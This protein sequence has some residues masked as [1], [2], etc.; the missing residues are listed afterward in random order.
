MVEEG[1][2]AKLKVTVAVTCKADKDTDKDARTEVKPTA[3]EASGG[4]VTIEGTAHSTWKEADACT[5]KATAEGAKEATGT[6]KVTA[7]SKE[8]EKEG[9]S[10]GDP[11]FS[12]ENPK[13]GQEFTITNGAGN[14][15]SLVPANGSGACSGSTL[16]LLKG[17]DTKTLEALTESHEIKDGDAFFVIGG[18]C[19]VDVE[20]IAEAKALATQGSEAVAI[21]SLDLS[22]ANIVLN[23]AA[24]AAA[25]R[26]SALLFTK[27]AE[28]GW[29]LATITPAWADDSTTLNSG[30]PK[31]SANA[32]N[33]VLLRT[34]GHWRYAVG[35]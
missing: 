24:T 29:V 34:N 18:S 16:Y 7:A 2:G 1:D 6:F 33:H 21:A 25:N 31:D 14:D 8:D 10:A 12:P 23:I 22:G 20:D 27:K 35:T 17:T 30:V 19:K 26:A 9:E 5:A 13:L 11:A 4:K 32:N 28:A 15:I 3:K